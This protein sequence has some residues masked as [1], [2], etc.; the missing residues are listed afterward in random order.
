M[1]LGADARSAST[2]AMFFSTWCEGRGASC[3]GRAE[4]LEECDIRVRGRAGGEQKREPMFERSKWAG[5][6]RGASECADAYEEGC[7]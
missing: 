4:G 1:P 6:I 3:T 2:L 5:A 7:D